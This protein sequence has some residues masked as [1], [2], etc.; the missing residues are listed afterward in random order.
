MLTDCVYT[1]ML[2]CPCFTWI[3]LIMTHE[4]VMPA[5]VV[6]EAVTF[7]ISKP[8]V[9]LVRTVSPDTTRGRGLV[10][11]GTHTNIISNIQHI[12]HTS[13]KILQYLFNLN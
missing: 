9:L 3:A 2:Y 12:G 10:R 7:N 8:A 5:C 4:E 13:G 6:V 11:S 1:L